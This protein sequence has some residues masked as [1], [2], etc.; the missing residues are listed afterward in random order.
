MHKIVIRAYNKN[1]YEAELFK[2]C[3]FLWIFYYWWSVDYAH[4][5]PDR[6]FDQ[7]AAWVDINDVSADNIIDYTENFS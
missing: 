6:M 2:K 4:G 3:L 1:L 7:V 5:S